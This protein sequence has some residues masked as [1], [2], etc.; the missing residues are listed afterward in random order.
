MPKI[1]V[2]GGDR[3]VENMF[4]RWGWSITTRVTDSFD[5]VQFTGG[6]DVSPS[7][8][9]EKKHPATYTNSARDEKESEV[10][11]THLGELPMAGICRGGQLLNVLNGGKMWQHVSNHN[12][13]HMAFDRLSEQPV[14]V[15]SVHHQMMIPA[16]SAKVLLI[17]QVCDMRQTATISQAGI[18]TD[19]EALFYKDKNCLCFQPHPEYV[20]INHEC[21]QL[22]FK[23]LDVCLGIR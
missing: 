2:V 5:M 6:S 12:S 11:Y 13:D 23:Y 19:I 17:A 4:T 7:L 9:G 18:D 16:E 3:L 1:L 10:F 20:D 22:Y 14:L 8:Y 21:Q 15:T